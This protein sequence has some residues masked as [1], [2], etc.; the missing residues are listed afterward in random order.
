MK[1]DNKRQTIVLTSIYE[2]DETACRTYGV[3]LESLQRYKRLFK[4]E[5]PERWEK[6]Q[7]MATMTANFLPSDLKVIIEAGKHKKQE[8]EIPIRSFEGSSELTFGF[9]TDTHIGSI[10][11]DEGYFRSAIAEMKQQNCEFICH[12]GDVTDGLSNRPQH[13]YELTHIGYAAQKEYAIE[14]LSL[15]DKPWYIIDGNHDSYYVQ[16]G[17][18]YIVKDICSHLKDAHYLGEN[19]GDC[20]IND[21]KFKLWHGLDASAYATSYRLQ[22]LVEAFASGQKPR[23]LLAGHTHKQVYMFERNV[24]IFSGGGLS[25]QSKWMLGKRLAQHTGFFVIKLKTK[26]GEILSCNST[27]YPFYS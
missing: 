3:S 14:L 8:Q 18:G 13:I 19:Q 1:E 21:V 10:Y 26:F 11:F 6:L 20:I 4:K 17:G 16:S 2:G 25:K 9:M 5:D 12:A 23:I 7:T 22:K 15:W 24:H 27:W